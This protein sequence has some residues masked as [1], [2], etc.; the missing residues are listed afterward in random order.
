MNSNVVSGATEPPVAEAMSTAGSDGG[1]AQGLRTRIVFG[2]LMAV[3]AVAAVASGDGVFALFVGAASVILAW[4]WTRLCGEG[5][6]GRTGVIVAVAMASVALLAFMDRLLLALTA[7][8]LAAPLVFAIARAGQ[9]AN[10]VW[11]ASGVIY[12]GLP[13]AALIWLR[14]H[15]ASGERMIFWLLTSIA[16]TD[17]GA[18]FAGRLIGGPKLAPSISPKKTW[19]GLIGAMV[20]SAGIGAGFAT[21]DST[22]PTMSTLAV[23]GASLAVVGQMGDLLE[24]GMKR[25]FGVKDSSSLIPGHGGLLDRVDGLITAAAAVAL[26]Q[27]ATAGSVLTWR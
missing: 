11:M 8:L 7:A 3:I 2:L 21:L 12:I 15:D 10:P 1:W 26:F 23:A 5:R 9:R 27:W 19:A 22:A 6:F 4:E 24:S 20:A 13:V 14:G 18:F 16:M 17:I 25:H